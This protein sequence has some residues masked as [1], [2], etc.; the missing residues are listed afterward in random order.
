[1]TGV[2]VAAVEPPSV[3]LS[4]PAA[5][6]ERRGLDTWLREDEKIRGS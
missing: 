2:Y 1:M 3:M 6:D 4:P 5:A